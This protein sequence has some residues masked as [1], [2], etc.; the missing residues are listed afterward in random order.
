MN[1]AQT[2]FEYIDPALKSAG[3]GDY[4]ST[5]KPRVRVF[6]VHIEFC[7][8]GGLPK[9][10]KV[11]RESD[12]SQPRNPLIAKIFRVIKLAET[13][14]YGFDKIF[15]GWRTYVDDEPIFIN[16]LDYLDLKMTTQKTTQK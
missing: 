15:K 12:I 14:G 9:E 4:F 6:I 10:L 16:G 3:L 7:N 11:L 8:P 1:E 2:E 5:S 13:A